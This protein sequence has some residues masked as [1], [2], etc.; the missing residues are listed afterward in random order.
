CKLS[1][2]EAGRWLDAANNVCALKIGGWS[3]IDLLLHDAEEA[4]RDRAE[5]ERLTYVAATRARDLL[6]VP[7]IGDA[8]YEGGWLDPLMPALY[9]PEPSRRTPQR[10]PGCPA[11]AS[12]DTVLNRP[13]GDPANSR[14]VA[15]GTFVFSVPSATHQ[16]TTSPVHQMNYSV[17]WWD[18]RALHLG[19]VSSFGLRRDDLIVK[20][21]DMFAVEER[22]AEYERWR[23]ARVTIAERGALPSV[24]VQTATAWAAEAATLGID[25]A[26]AEPADIAVIEMPGAEKRPRGARFG[27][28]VHA[29]LATVPL[30]APADVVARTAGTQGRVLNAGVSEIAAAVSVVSDVLR[31]DLLARVRASS[32]VKRETPVSWLQKDGVLIEG[33]L[34]LAFEENGATIV[35]DFK[36]DYELAAGETRYRAQLQQYVNAVARA[37]AR[38]ASGILFKV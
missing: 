15:P 27:T 22:L 3:P 38:P 5:S 19:A 12:K 2:A 29:V 34:D 33:V 11:F 6:V 21:G 23:D 9:P 32:S 24:R 20:D 13:G 16:L 8:P 18:P 26:L 14:T 37:T 7:A 35:V 10:A 17:T 36:T 28:L 30:D 25:L 1:R 31:H 4:A